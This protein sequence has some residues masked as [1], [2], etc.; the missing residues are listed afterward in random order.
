MIYD[1]YHTHTLY[2]DGTAYPVS[3]VK[4]AVSLG[5]SA[6]GFTDHASLPF[7]VEWSMPKKKEQNYLREIIALK[8][9][10]AEQI[11]LLCGLEIDYIPGVSEHFF[12]KQKRLGLDYTIGAVHF[13][14]APDNKRLW[15][16]DGSGDG[17]H[18][19]L[20]NL[21][22]GNIQQAVITYYRQIRRML[23]YE[24]V[25]ILGHFDK[26]KMNNNDRFFSTKEPWY[27][28]EIRLTL[29][30]I[31][32]NGLIVEINTRGIY[33]K[34]YKETFPSPEIIHTCQKSGIPLMLNADAHQPDELNMGFSETILMIKDIGVRSLIG[35]DGNGF[36]MQSI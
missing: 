32:K 9:Q 10:Y 13:V 26:I 35:Y 15:F 23:Q 11:N 21:F 20:L 7:F 16:I 3:Y 17:F 12:A 27:R 34:R 33:K 31:K 14:V 5:C 30:A 22:N 36:S 1:N 6:L 25:T 29:E 18:Y 2:S 19:G 4:K 24:Q 28:R 8:H